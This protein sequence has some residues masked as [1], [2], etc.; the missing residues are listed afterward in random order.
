MP[1]DSISYHGSQKSRDSSNEAIA[2]VDLKPKE[3][4]ESALKN[5]ARGE[6]LFIDTEGRIHTTK[7]PFLRGQR[8]PLV[9]LTA[10][11]DGFVVNSGVPPRNKTYVGREQ[12]VSQGACSLKYSAMVSSGTFIGLTELCLFEVPSSKDG[13]SDPRTEAVTGIEGLQALLAYAEK[14]DTVV[15][16]RSAVTSGTLPGTV[17]RQHVTAF[18]ADK[19]DNGDGTFVLFLRLKLGIPSEE[20]VEVDLGNGYAPVYGE[21]LVNGGTLKAGG[22][23]EIRIPH[24][25]GSI[26]ERSYDSMHSL[27]EFG[28]L[29]HEFHREELPKMEQLVVAAYLSKGLELIRDGS[30]AD[31]HQL[32]VDGAAVLENA[33]YSLLISNIH[34]AISPTNGMT[35]QAIEEIATYS[36]CNTEHKQLELVSALPPSIET[37]NAEQIEKLEAYYKEVSLIYARVY[38]CLLQELGEK[39]ISKSAVLIE[40][41]SSEAD[42]AAYFYEHGVLS[43]DLY[44]ERYSDLPNAIQI[45]EGYQTK[46]EQRAFEDALNTSQFGDFVI[47]GA[48]LFSDELGTE[49]RRAALNNLEENEGA[50]RRNTDG[51]YTLYA[52]HKEGEC[53][54]FVAD[55]QGVYGRLEGDSNVLLEP[56][57]ILYLG[58]G[59]RLE[60]P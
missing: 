42:I 52:P 55:R 47:I 36:R 41:L 16:G 19:T 59:F 9:T 3:R 27:V 24:P 14:G 23:G 4:I 46:D 48:N 18:V 33:R 20:V 43:S 53:A 54:I 31:A 12:D 21:R 60:L 38:G 5:L 13:L 34:Q 37:T 10:T 58:R 7:E 1:S 30:Y 57:A 22:L 6:Q 28:A 39:P 50:I 11:A 40:R 8:T 26:E 29:E 17:S 51:T 35:T 56:G 44:A 15:L 25:R 2:P 32:F 45:L 49:E